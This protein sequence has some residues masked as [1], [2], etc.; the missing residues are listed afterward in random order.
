M[1][2]LKLQ[3]LLA[4]AI[5]ELTL[6]HLTTDE[7]K[8]YAPS[9]RDEML[10]QKGAELMVYAILVHYPELRSRLLKDVVPVL[11]QGLKPYEQ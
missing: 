9:I 1:K 4:D 5:T 7:V 6:H 2:S 10:M 8:K 3:P 11:P